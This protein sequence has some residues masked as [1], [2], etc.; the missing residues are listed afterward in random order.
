MRR[1]I[2]RTLVLV[3]QLGLLAVVVGSDGLKW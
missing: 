2:D 1:I 3:T